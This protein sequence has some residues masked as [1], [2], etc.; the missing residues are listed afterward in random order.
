MRLEAGLPRSD[1]LDQKLENA[2]LDVMEYRWGKYRIRLTKPDLHKNKEL[3]SDLL[4]QA[5]EAARV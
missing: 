3:V 5:D 4:R 1:E 2:G